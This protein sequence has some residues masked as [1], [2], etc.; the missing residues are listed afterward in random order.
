MMIDVISVK[1]RQDSTRWKGLDPI[2]SPVED[3]R[4]MMTNRRLTRI[5]QVGYKPIRR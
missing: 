4:W 3:R 2:P 5:R 1:D